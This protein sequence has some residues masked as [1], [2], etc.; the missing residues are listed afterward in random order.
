[1]APLVNVRTE[2][3][4]E[5][6]LPPMSGLQKFLLFYLLLM[7]VL[8]LLPSFLPKA[9]LLTQK[10]GS[11]GSVGIVLILFSLL[12]V[13][14]VEGKSLVNFRELAHQKIAWEL[15]F[16]CAMALAISSFLTKPETGITTLLSRILNP[17]F[18]D[19]SPLVFIFLLCF[20]AIVLTNVGNNGVIAM[21]M[22]TVSCLYVGNYH[23]NPAVV[24][25][26]L[27]YCTNIAFLLPAS[28]MFGALAHG[29]E[30]LEAKDIYAYAVFV[31]LVALVVTVFIGYPLA[32]WLL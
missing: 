21:L 32:I 10:L 5:N 26:L 12:C 3:F 7:I 6:K 28:S 29:N 14:Q 1:M 24:V 9:W 20:L 18:L 13:I 4:T 16:L 30:W 25:I 11:A 27:G 8:L 15:V 19:K 23:I 31:A 2:M 22:M 17:I